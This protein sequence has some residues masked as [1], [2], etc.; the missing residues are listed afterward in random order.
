MPAAYARTLDGDNDTFRLPEDFLAWVPPA[1][2]NNPAVFTYIEKFKHA[3]YGPDVYGDYRYPRLLYIWGHSFE[4]E[5]NG[6]WDRMEKIC[7]ALEGMEDT[8]YATNIEICDYVTAYYALRFSADGTL[9]YNPTATKIRFEVIG[10]KT[11]V[12]DPG[13]TLKIDNP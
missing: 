10:D 11:Y 13:Q 8:Y 9:V 12:I 6:N 1:H 4:F 5:N 3:G 7:Q 2:H